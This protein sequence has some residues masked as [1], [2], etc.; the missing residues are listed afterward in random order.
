MKIGL[1]TGEYPPMEGGVGAFTCKLAKEFSRNGNEV[2]IITSRLARPQ[3]DDRSV[4][5]IKEPY[6]KGYGQLHARINRWWWGSMSTI[7]QIVNRYDLEIINVQYQAAAFDM[8]IPAINFLPWRLRGLTN[9]VVTFHDFRV[10]YL[11]PKAGWLRHRMVQNLVKTSSGVIVTNSEDYNRL[12]E[13][14]ID[15]LRITQLPI[16]SNIDAREPT[17]L[18]IERIRNALLSNK[19]GVLLGYFGFLSETKGANI[20]LE[21][22][23]GLPDHF[24]LV[25]IGGQ[26]GSSDTSRNREFLARLNG[27]IEELGIKQR[28]HWS[29][30]LADEDVSAFLCSCEMMVLPY[31]DG[32]SLRRG[33]LMAS[34]AHGCPIVTTLP[35]VRIDELIHGEN[36]WMTPVDDSDELADAIVHLAED[37]ALR[38]KLG[39]GAKKSSA[40][41]SWSDIAAKT[42]SFYETIIATNV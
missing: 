41:F 2:H 10:P 26:T 16:G 39:A 33:T 7:A 19:N 40:Q 25:F 29:G 37:S 27:R 28:V 15:L 17:S 4:W 11:F 21:A 18:E 42:E 5:D 22:L 6:D 14:E 9:T 20:L 32:A 36:V 12:A 3:N 23:A 31:R 34:L 8:N 24:E 13:T 35:S 30:F 1:V 38:A